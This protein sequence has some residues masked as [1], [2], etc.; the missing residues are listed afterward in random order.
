MVRTLIA[1]DHKLVLAGFR[2]LLS[3]I[4]GIQIVGEA[5]NGRDA[6]HLAKST[7]PDLVLMDIRMRELN[8]IDAT[9]IIKA[10]SPETHVLIVSMHSEEEFVLR[11]LRAGASGYL[12]KDC[13]PPE[14]ELAIAAVMR[15]E[16]YLTPR[17]SRQ[18]VAGL[19]RDTQNAPAT[20]G[21]HALTLRHREI[22]QL[23][24]EGKGTKQIAQ[25]LGVSV[26]TIETHRAAIMQR[27]DLHSVAELVLFG[28]RNKLVPLDPPE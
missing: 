27:L 23:I 5:D 20:N 7:R 3:T 13:A 2:S 9:A 19:M 11:A 26:K 15:G 18:V 28:I 14:L 6:V 21:L 25:V 16:I 22:L 10:D 8:G 17:I 1:E 24:V 4:E 12:V